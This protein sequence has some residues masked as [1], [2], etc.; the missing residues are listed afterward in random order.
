MVN[1]TPIIEDDP[2]LG[3]FV[4]N[5]PSNR[6]RSLLIAVFVCG[7]TATMLSLGLVLFED[8]WME[9]IALVGMTSVTVGMWWVTAHT[10]HREVVLYRHGFTYREGSRTVSFHLNELAAIRQRAERLAY[11]GGLVRR[12]VYRFTL[13]THAGET[14]VLDNTYLRVGEL[15]ARLEAFLNE[16][17]RPIVKAQLDAGEQ[18]AFAETLALSKS[19]LHRGAESLDWGDF[20]GYRV[21]NRQVVIESQAGDW[22]SVPLADMDNITLLLSLLKERQSPPQVIE[23]Q[24][25]EGNS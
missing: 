2:I 7:F 24:E 14:I 17:L 4:A 16:T 20:A 15:G 25:K 22:H 23:L 11:F 13:R 1:D 8:W 19:G 6:L 10:W 18:V 3:A 9:V 12:S 5:Y 21:A